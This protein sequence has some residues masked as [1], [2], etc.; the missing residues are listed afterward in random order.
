M[1]RENDE[2]EEKL[3]ERDRIILAMLKDAPKGLRYRELKQ[4]IKNDA[5]LSKRLKKLECLYLV[6]RHVNIK[7][8]VEVQVNN[9]H[10]VEVVYTLADDISLTDK[11]FGLLYGALDTINYGRNINYIISKLEAKSWKKEQKKEVVKESYLKLYP[12]FLWC[13]SYA[14]RA[15]SEAAR[16]KIIKLYTDAVCGEVKDWTD[17]SRK[18][19]QIYSEFIESAVRHFNKV[20]LK[21]LLDNAEK[22]FVSHFPDDLK[23]LASG[24]FTFY[25]Q[26]KNETETNIL[27]AFQN[28]VSLRPEKKRFEEYLGENIPRYRLNKFLQI[29]TDLCEPKRA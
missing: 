7:H 9:K 13:L 20:E 24:Y 18:Y 11:D 4:K 5:T 10:P 27:Q 6:K 12:H 1:R 17:R 14:S 22:L 15:E 8:P 25:F 16:R 26:A 19:Y 23:E 2:D 21:H 28:I 29:L 3:Y